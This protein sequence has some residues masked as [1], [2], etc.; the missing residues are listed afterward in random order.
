V[1]SPSIVPL[2]MPKW[3]LE[4]G[5][6]T[7]LRWYVKEGDRLSVGQELVDIET[8]KIAN[9]VESTAAGTLRRI[10][11][12]PGAAVSVGGLIGVIAESVV[13]DS[14]IDEFLASFRGLEDRP[15]GA[16][17]MG[18]DARRQAVIDGTLISYAETG[19]GAGTPVLLIHG[20]GGDLSGWALNVGPLA[21]QRR[22]I[23][24][25]LPGHGASSKQ[26]GDGSAVALAR[27]VCG[28]IDDVA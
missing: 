28:F 27:T 13:S 6:G 21:E 3:G 26:I 2:T 4:M 23:A 11:A 18:A 1:K 8:S 20:F 24:L 5:E 25:D 22:V 17:P 16:T 12:Q 15:G 9:A 14:Q 7:I 19:S 10:V